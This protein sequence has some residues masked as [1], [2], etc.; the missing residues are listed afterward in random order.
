MQIRTAST[1]CAL[2][3]IALAVFVWR[4]CP[5]EASQPVSS[6]AVHREHDEDPEGGRTPELTVGDRLPLYPEA[7]IA[8]RGRVL[9]VDG[10]PI[11]GARVLWIALQKEDVEAIPAWPS[12]GW[13]VPERLTLQAGTSRDGAFS[14]EVEPAPELPFGSV[15][16]ALRSG[17]LAGGIDLAAG[18]EQL[19]AAEVV[20]E[21]ALDTRVHVVAVGGKGQGGATVR[22]VGSE[23]SSGAND[24]RPPR[25]RRFLEQSAITDS[26]G[27]VDLP[28]FPGEQAIWAEQGERVSV[29]WQGPR[30]SSVTLTLGESFT[31][32]GTIALPDRATWDAAR[33]GERRM[34]VWGQTG[35]LWRPLANIRDLHEGQWG[36]VRIPLDGVSRYRVRLEGAPIMPIEELFAAPRAGT[37]KSLDFIATRHA[38]L[39]LYVEDE[40]GKP[41]DKATAIAWWNPTI[42]PAEGLYVEGASRPDGHLDL[43]GLPHGWV[44]YRVSA[45]GHQLLE[46][47]DEVP[48]EPVLITLPRAGRITGHCFHADE[49]VPDFEVIYWKE[50]NPQV[51]R[52]QSFYGR[53]DGSFELESLAPGDWSLHASSEDHP[54]GA[55]VVVNVSAEKEA[56]AR[57]SIP[58]AIRGVGQVLDAESGE[59]ITSARV[60]VYS[61]GGLER[62]YPWGPPVL[63]AQDGTFEV[64]AFV[65]GTN[66]LV[67]TA[68][69]YADTEVQAVAREQDLLDW[70]E[71]RVH[72]PQS[73]ELQLLG[74]DELD[75]V[76]ATELSA[77][78]AEGFILP[79]KLFSADGLVRYDAVPPGDHR[80]GVTYPDSMWARL[81]LRLDPGKEWKFD[82]RVGG[83]RSLHVRVAPPEGEDVAGKL[84]LACCQE[85]NGIFVLRLRPTSSE[86]VASF[87]GIRASKVQVWLLA[88]DGSMASSRDYSF[89]DRSTLEVEFTRDDVPLRV[90][91]VDSSRAPLAGAWVTVRSLTGGEVH[92]VD[93]TDSDG[94]AVLA[95]M[96]DMPLLLDVQ[97]G[98]AGRRQGIPVDASVKEHE[99]VLAAEG[100]LEIRVADGAEPLSAVAAR[101]ETSGG[102]TLSDALQADAA[103]LVSFE[104][105][106]EGT[107]R[108][109]LQ[110]SDC[111]PTIVEKQLG[112]GEQ[113]R[114]EVQMRRLADL[115]LTLLDESGLLVS[116]AEVAL[117]SAEFA[118]DIDTW[119]KEE[120]VRAPNGLT[121][122]VRGVIRIESLPRGVYTW[123]VSFEDKPLS[124][125]FE[126]AAAEVNRVS[127]RLV[128]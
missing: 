5:G 50:G 113:A 127:I 89:G 15:L 58:E 28:S 67:V 101:I 95:G 96:A 122:D 80:L 106:G 19:A 109:G 53:S 91:V 87:H 104:A 40:S 42:H 41:I 68:E 71:I 65:L 6:S 125:T 35:S 25:Y 12:P 66:Y 24:M 14:F 103:G 73:L 83:P 56:Y 63:A 64:D 52:R 94:W 22:H 32:G 78:T 57:I 33:E 124:G 97:H 1:L 37:H 3:A 61:S 9:S 4:Q 110:R 70:G 121:T 31:I 7:A 26:E 86:G 79:R 43:G 98:I 93:D 38:E 13:G 20:L 44:R 120:R 46:G 88:E 74:L 126:L 92:G 90:R 117:A 54:C 99:I 123:S 102:V 17:F 119:L 34:R 105:L 36:P 8:L 29:P 62:S 18:E 39:T 81:Q 111:W 82:F 69:G 60:Q 2:A 114:L 75:G 59:P 116:G 84:M 128:H 27:R 115:E 45:P 48:R 107:Y 30:P 51:H 10:V 11:E 112:A 55:P 49:P 108:I 118:A 100:S 47:Q 72:R 16:V 85:D 77:S 23:R 21:P 76:R